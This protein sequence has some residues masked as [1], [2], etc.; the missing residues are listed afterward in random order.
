[1]SQLARPLRRPGTECSCW[2]DNDRAY[3]G[4]VIA[5]PPLDEFDLDIRLAPVVVMVGPADSDGFTCYG[6]PDCTHISECRQCHT[7]TCPHETCECPPASEGCASDLCQPSGD[8]CPRPTI[9]N[10]A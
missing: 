4:G 6:G 3:T 2:P 1:C 10:C 8:E 5:R 7:V 9:D